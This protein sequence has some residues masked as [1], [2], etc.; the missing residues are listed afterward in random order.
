M[1]ILV[2]FVFLFGFLDKAQAVKRIFAIPRST[3]A[4]FAEFDA[5]P[6]VVGRVGVFQGFVEGDLAV[7]VQVVQRRVEGTHAHAFRLLHDFLDFGDRALLDQVGNPARIQQ[8]FDG[9]TTLAVYGGDQALRY[10]CLQVDR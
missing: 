2:F 6:Q 8:D 3:F 1:D 5:Q 9:G 4:L 10:E 7:L